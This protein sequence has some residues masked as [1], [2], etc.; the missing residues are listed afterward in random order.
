MPFSVVISLLV[1]YLKRH[2]KTGMTQCC[3]AN[4]AKEQYT[5]AGEKF[6]QILL[7]ENCTS[8]NNAQ[9]CAAFLF[10]PSLKIIPPN[11]SI[12]RTLGY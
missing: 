2:S 7:H 1:S 3:V 6:R 5:Q 11:W 8:F 12:L 10:S 4:S 9:I